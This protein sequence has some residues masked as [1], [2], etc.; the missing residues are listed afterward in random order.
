MPYPP[1]QALANDDVLVAWMTSFETSPSEKNHD[2]DVVVVEIMISNGSSSS[3]LLTTMSIVNVARMWLWKM[4]PISSMR[5]KSSPDQWLPPMVID[6]LSFPFPLT[7][8]GD[9]G[10]LIDVVAAAAAAAAFAIPVVGY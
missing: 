8:V 2:D 10:G 7:V 3:S 5:N 9:C 1:P 4:I 6:I